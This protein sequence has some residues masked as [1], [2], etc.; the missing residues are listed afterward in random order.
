MWACLQHREGRLEP[1]YLDIQ[2][3][4]DPKRLEDPDTPVYTCP[5]YIK[6]MERGPC[7]IIDANI[8][9]KL[10]SNIQS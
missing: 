4:G 1:S 3:E 9:S 6:G 8:V 10:Y 5:D 7:E 2:V